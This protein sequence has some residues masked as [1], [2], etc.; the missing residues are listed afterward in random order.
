MT[1]VLHAITMITSQMKEI[2]MRESLIIREGKASLKGNNQSTRK[3]LEK[4]IIT[5]HLILILQTNIQELNLRGSIHMV[6]S[7]RK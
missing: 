3:V 4:T 7:A 5:F 2:A 6:C 1:A